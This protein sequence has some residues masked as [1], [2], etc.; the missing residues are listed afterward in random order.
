M[1]RNLVGLAAYTERW[2]DMPIRCALARLGLLGLFP[3]WNYRSLE[4]F[5]AAAALSFGVL[6]AL[7]ACFPEEPSYH[8]MLTV[9]PAGVWGAL[10]GSVGF[11]QGFGALVPLPRFARGGSLLGVA[12][13]AYVAFALLALRPLSPAAPLYVLLSLANIAIHIRG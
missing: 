12:L 3:D 7:C 4:L 11:L 6:I 13:W 10:F 9:L 5:C 1:R 2:S 8:R